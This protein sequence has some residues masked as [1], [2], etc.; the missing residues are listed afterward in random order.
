M[1]TV[2]YPAGSRGMWIVSPIK[3]AE[4]KLETEVR[5]LSAGNVLLLSVGYP[6]QNSQ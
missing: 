1:C 3:L 6:I 5:R 4:N 2:A